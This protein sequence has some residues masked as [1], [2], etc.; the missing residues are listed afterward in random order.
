MVL[1]IYD[2]DQEGELWGSDGISVEKFK[3][4]QKVE[5][6]LSCS[7][8]MQDYSLK[9]PTKKEQIIRMQK[10]SDGPVSSLDK[11]GVINYLESLGNLESFHSLTGDVFLARYKSLSQAVSQI[12]ETEGSNG[13][14]LIYAVG[15]QPWMVYPE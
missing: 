7:T 13:N 11:A 8:N 5:F 1:Y 2:K 6:Q 12:R 9:Q 4:I 10:L 14:M 3:R 15:V